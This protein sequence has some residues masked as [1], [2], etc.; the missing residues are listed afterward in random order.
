MDE[1]RGIVPEGRDRDREGASPVPVEP[2]AEPFG[3]EPPRGRRSRWRSFLV[4]AVIAA[5]IGAAVWYFPRTQRQT[6]PGRF[7]QPSAPIPVGVATAER[8]DM[9]VTL[10]G[11]GTVTPLATVTVQTQISGYLMSVGFQEGQHVKKGDFLAQIDPRPYQVALQQDQA[12]LFK[13]QASLKGAE[14]DLARYNTLAAQKSIA[15]QTRD[16]QIYTVAQDKAQVQVDQA[17]IDT[18]KLNLV[19]CHITSSVTGRVGL[20]QVD[21]GNYVTPTNLASG[22]VVVTQTQPIS[23]IFTLPEDNLP[24]VLR[25][26]HAGAALPVTA[27]DR[28]GTAKI[29]AGRLETVDNQIDTT[30]GMVKLRAIFD[31]A[32]ESLFPNQFVNIKLLVRTLKDAVLVP[33]AAIQRGAPGTFVYQV[34]PNSTVAVRQVAVGPNDGERVAVLSG[35]QAGDRVV[36]DGT[37]RLKNGAKISIAPTPGQAASQDQGGRSQSRHSAQPHRPAQPKSQ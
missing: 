18:Q 36:D 28:T 21:P 6:A 23:V 16:D 1:L 26:S 14:T 27:Y 13:D 35:L 10:S 2:V 37:D 20:R 7:G 15:L 33:T 22:I 5:I 3:Q 9:P 31:N 30:T 19:Y 8:G 25:Q 12:Q 11:L 34:E 24:E 32:D 17:Q 29:A 4:L